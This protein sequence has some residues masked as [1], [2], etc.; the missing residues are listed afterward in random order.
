MDAERIGLDQLEAIHAVQLPAQVL[1][2]ARVQLDGHDRCARGKQPASE[3]AEAGAD[4]DHVVAGLELRGVDDGIQRLR[5]GQEV[6][7]QALP[8][9]EPFGSHEPPKLARGG[10]RE[11]FGCERVAHAASQGSARFGIASSAASAR[12]PAAKRKPAAAPIMAPLSVHHAGGGTSSGSPSAVTRRLEGR[13]Q[14]AVGR[15]PAAERDRRD[16]MVA[17]R[18]H[19]L[20]GE[21]V[22]DGLL[23]GGGDPVDR[24]RL[25]PGAV[26]LHLAQD[27]GLEPREAEV[28]RARGACAREPGRRRCVPR[29]GADGGAARIRQAE[30]PPDLVE[31]LARRV[32]DRLA[33]EACTARGRA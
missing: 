18:R 6:L 19:G 8:G 1:R 26:P 17:R 3:D 25:V 16:A 29:G 32:V 21:R 23:E 7:R 11:P 20:R 12:S 5:I 30:Q 14:R 33:Q 31:R 28:V 2:Q 9:S 27:R 24:D 22:D 10:W 13:A 15:H 4:L